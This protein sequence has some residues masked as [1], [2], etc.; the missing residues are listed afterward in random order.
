MGTLPK[1]TFSVSL[2]LDV[3]QRIEDERRKRDMKRSTFI[4]E[5][6]KKEF[7]MKYKLRE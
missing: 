1:V 5:I 6:L 4:E 2:S 7:G 3:Y